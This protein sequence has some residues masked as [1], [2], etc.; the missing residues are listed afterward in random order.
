MIYTQEEYQALEHFKDHTSQD[1]NGRYMV[2]LPRKEPLPELGQSR[3]LALKPF[4]QNEKLLKRK[5]QWESFSSA[6]Q[7]YGN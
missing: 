4:L 6:V 5:G 1:N 2:K 3:P 7:E